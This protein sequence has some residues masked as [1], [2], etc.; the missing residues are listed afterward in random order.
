M[1]T[2][3]LV[4]GARTPIGKFLG[5][6]RNLT[7]VELG[8][9]AI[10][11]A[12]EKG[13]VAGSEVDLVIMGQ[14]L[15]AG[16]GP[17]PARQAAASAGLGM[18]TPALTIN[19]L[20][21]SGLHAIAL[22]DQQIRL[23]QAEVVVA[24]G[25]ESMSNVPHLLA[26]SRAGYKYGA[27]QL[28]DALDQDALICAFDGVSMG[29]AT[30]GYQQTMGI[31]RAEQDEYAVRSHEMA[32]KAQR[33]G[34]FEHEIAPVAVP[35]GRGK[36]VDVAA[37]EGIRDDLTVAG[38]AQLKPAFSTNGTIT[39]ASS[40]PLSDGGCAVLIM[41]K[42]RAEFLSIPWLAEI[43]EFGF[44][45]GPDASLLGQPAAAIRAALG[46]DG[47]TSIDQLDLIEINEAFAGVAIQSVR[48]LNI[49][50]QRLNVN[51]GAI[52]LGHPV[53]M[54]GARLALTAALELQRRGGGNAVAALCGGGGQ[55]AA[56]L[57]RSSAA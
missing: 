9:A 14:V 29:R 4:A 2:S 53:G 30:D 44:V 45:A 54:S 3:V 52:A 10:R 46:R 18:Q 19:D 8:A 1:T 40:S 50:P 26:G 31:S 33:A 20:C 57:L 21:L 38:L 27:A 25:M 43:G 15:Q 47:T 12:L 23:G 5:E 7:A 37:D 11:G 13:N 6:L 36:R 22:A 42:R 41:S 51:G 39:A 56:L 24:G 16:S 55:G 28:V 34:K 49:D 35:A 32:G 17:N 48:E